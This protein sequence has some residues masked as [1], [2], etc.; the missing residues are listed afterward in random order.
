MMIPKVLHRIWVGG[1]MPAKYQRFEADWRRLHPGWEFK[2][3][4]DGDL[5]WLQNREL[6]DNAERFVPKDAVGQ[7]RADVAR[8]EILSRF[9]GVYVDCDVEPKR[10]FDPLLGVEGFAG[11]EEQER[12]VGNTVLGS[13]PGNPFF[14]EMVRAVVDS[15]KANVGRAATWLSGPRVVTR[16]YNDNRNL[17]KHLTVY[18][19]KYFF[20]YSY[21][22]LRRGPDPAG[23]E[24]PDAYSVHHWGHQRELRGRPLPD[25]SDGSLSVA[26]MAHRKR[27]AWVPELAAQLPGVRI[28]WDQK[29]NRWDTGSRALSAYDPKAE[30]H[31][32]VQDDALLPEDFFEG[33]K[34]M[35]GHVPVGHPV[36]LYYGRVRPREHDTRTLTARAQREKAP[37]I[38]HNGPWW[39]VGIVV[40]TNHIRDIVAWGAE[41][42][43]IANYDRRIARYYAEIDVPCYYPQ[44]SLIEHRHGVENPSLVP[45]RT[46]LNRRAW[47][48]VG[49]R[50]A[51]SVDWSGTPVRGR[52]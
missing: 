22:D 18:P 31:M 1:P 3:W 39:G 34:R 5:L 49:P 16:V 43:Q 9:G 19:Q 36:G 14:A 29:N 37:F 32:V 21:T 50:S 44:P 12:F 25:A 8:Y 24:Y 20:P 52:V 13:A 30:W 42:P 35:L 6:F 51:L 33:V 10:C 26:I 40:P 45:G 28:V 41:N 4:G 2:T 38:V 17:Q 7:F 47:H 46:S 48:F 23:R 27:E 11:W 15:S